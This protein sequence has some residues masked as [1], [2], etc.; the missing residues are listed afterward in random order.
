MYNS[1][2]MSDSKHQTGECISMPNYIDI[3]EDERNFTRHGFSLIGELY[4]L[5]D[6][7]QE[8][9]ETKK[10]QYEIAVCSEIMTIDNTTIS[11]IPCFIFSG[12]SALDNDFLDYICQRSNETTNLFLKGIYNSILWH[13]RK[14]NS[15]GDKAAQ[16]FY[17]FSVKIQDPALVAFSIK[18]AIIIANA[19]RNQRILSTS[20]QFL[21]LKFKESNEGEGKVLFLRIIIDLKK[22]LAMLIDDA[23]KQTLLD[24]YHSLKSFQDIPI[25]QDSLKLYGDTDITSRKEIYKKIAELCKT[26]ADSEADVLVKLHF[27][28]NAA[29]NYKFA[30]ETDL[31]KQCEAEYGKLW[32]DANKTIFKKN[33]INLSEDTQKGLLAQ[34]KSWSTFLENKDQREVLISLIEIP[35]RYFNYTQALKEKTNGSLPIRFYISST[36]LYNSSGNTTTINSE[37][38]YRNNMFYENLHLQKCCFIHPY[39]QITMINLCKSSRSIICALEYLIDEQSWIKKYPELRE[40]II[41][42]I[43]EYLCKSKKYV[44]S[45]FSKHQSFISCIDSMT[46]KAEL[47]LRQIF[48]S[49]NISV[50]KQDS[51]GN[52]KEI[53]INEMLYSSDINSIITN[54]NELCFLRF[55]L[56]DHMGL[57]LRNIVAHGL[58]NTPNDLSIYTWDNANLIFLVILILLFKANRTSD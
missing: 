51:R 8:E 31:Q 12:I 2:N 11:N 9:S 15:F 44:K 45:H 22:T 40:Q 3:L 49:K 36:Q 32:N 16:C 52:N 43:T 5:Y 14:N 53:D 10:I 17:D 56:I 18:Q 25:L 39:T 30:K 35:N 41:Q 13:C 48:I 38:E 29:K 21:L 4:T 19:C 54:E 27:L 57:N 58:T 6:T 26:K 20:A 55:V 28:K 24:Y 1:Y 37:E 34:Y 7:E 33:V 50:K 47:L 23:F 46:L 42:P